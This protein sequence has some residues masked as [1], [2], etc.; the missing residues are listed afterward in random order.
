V[1]SLWLAIAFVFG[2]GAR[3]LGLP[4]LVGYLIAGFALHALGA[5]SGGL[6]DEIADIGVL[7]MLFSIGLKLQLK[8]LARPV[9]WAGATI[10][11]LVTVIALGAVVLGLA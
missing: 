1:E 10:H 9:I 5:R 3:R 11:M 8:T 7:L 4:P 6:V 2:Y